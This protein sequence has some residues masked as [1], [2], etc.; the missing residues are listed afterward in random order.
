M[1][2]G[3]HATTAWR[4]RK[5]GQFA[6]GPSDEP[7][8]ARFFIALE[9]LMSRELALRDPQSDDLR[10]TSDGRAVLR[11]LS[12]R[13]ESTLPLVLYQKHQP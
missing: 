6:A 4:L 12:D 13:P 5:S 2:A 10:V 9:Q 3:L 11:N 1:K 7:S 8:N